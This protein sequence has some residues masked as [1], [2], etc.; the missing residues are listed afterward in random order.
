MNICIAWTIDK[1]KTNITRRSK[2]ERKLQLPS[3]FGEDPQN[4]KT[5]AQMAL[6]NVGSFQYLMYKRY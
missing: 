5:K 1:L 2:T 6:E 3:K 4:V